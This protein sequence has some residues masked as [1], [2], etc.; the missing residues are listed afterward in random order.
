[1]TRRFLALAAALGVFG[2]DRGTKWLV[3]TRFDT[4]DTKPLIPGLLNIIHSENPG[5]AFGI[6]QDGISHNR[7]LALVA[8]SIIAVGVLAWLLWRIDRQD[9]YTAA[10]ITLIF[11]GALGNV[12]DRIRTGQVTDFIDFYTGSYHWYTFN[13]ADAAI[14]IGAGLLILGMFLAEKA[15]QNVP[16]AIPDR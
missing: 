4:W 12:F 2:L 1:M 11:G 9:R 8:M 7:T 15:A 13:L 16:T 6:F 3:E 10:G 5:I 14:C